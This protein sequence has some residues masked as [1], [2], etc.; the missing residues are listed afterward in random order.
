[1]LRKNNKQLGRKENY[2]PCFKD[3]WQDEIFFGDE[4]LSEKP[5]LF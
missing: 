3:E 1:M 5:N 4:V 2:K